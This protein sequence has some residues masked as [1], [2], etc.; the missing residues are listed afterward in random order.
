MS[1]IKAK[2]LLLE[3]WV[4]IHSGFLMLGAWLLFFAVLPFFTTDAIDFDAIS[5]HLP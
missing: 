2:W 3:N 5:A 4:I 1:N